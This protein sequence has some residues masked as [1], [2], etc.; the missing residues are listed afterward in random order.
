MSLAEFD[1]LLHLAA[2]GV[3]VGHLALRVGTVSGGV[4]RDVQLVRRSSGE[5]R[6]Q[7]LVPLH[8][9]A[10]AGT[11][12]AALDG[13]QPLNVAQTYLVAVVDERRARHRQQERERNAQLVRVERPC[14]PVHVVV[15]GGNADEPLAVS[16]GV[17]R[18]VRRDELLSGALRALGEVRFLAAE[19]V[20]VVGGSE[21]QQEIHVEPADERFV[22][23]SP[24]AYHRGGGE[25][26]VQELADVLPQR[27][28]ALAV[29]VVLYE[30]ARH[31]N[32]ESV[33]AHGQPEAHDILERLAGSYGTGSVHRLL[34][35]AVGLVESVVQR[36]LVGEEVDRAGAVT[37]GNAADAA[38]SLRGFPDAVSPDVAVGELV[39]LRFHGFPEPLVGD[40][41]VTGH[42]V[43]QDVHSPG[44]SLG[45]HPREVLVG[46]VARR[47]GV[48]VLHVVARVA[49]RR[50]E[51]GVYPERVAA[52]L[53]D[54]I[55]L[56]GDTVE[57]ADSVCVG[58]VEGLG[59]YFV[60][61]CVVEPFGLFCNTHVRSPLR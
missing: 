4:L 17:V 41:G 52:E 8:G 31:V 53:P 37:V 33:A 21:V 55:Q 15:A 59:V 13:G 39:A 24:L 35:V 51:A 48:V 44:V 36:G 9:G 27:D 40:C 29:L 61:Y 6:V 38:H 19:Q 28:G 49:E 60:E 34:P 23:F 16:F 2:Q 58:V 7:P 42:E 45:E 47:G 46:A 32:A 26:L 14:E 43:E 25:L 22:R 3:R 10:R 20:V 56:F 1:E 18:L 12:V 5:S 11:S 57:I 54:V 30:G 50:L